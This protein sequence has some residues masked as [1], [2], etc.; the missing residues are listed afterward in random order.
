MPACDCCLI[1]GAMLSHVCQVASL[2]Q[3][4]LAWEEMQSPPSV[5][6]SVRLFPLYISN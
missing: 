1:V 2:L 4:A 3:T 5:R 6:L